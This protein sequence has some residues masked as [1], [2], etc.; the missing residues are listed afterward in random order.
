MGRTYGPRL[1]LVVLILEPNDNFSCVR[2]VTCNAEMCQ[3][4]F[5]REKMQRRGYKKACGEQES[6]RRE[7][8]SQ[9]DR[10]KTKMESG[11]VVRY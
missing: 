5:A 3:L 6:K 11:I 9:K 1:P 8:E 2:Q 4:V 10:I 7:Q